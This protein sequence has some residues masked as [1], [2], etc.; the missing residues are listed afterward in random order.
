[1]HFHLIAVGKRMPAWIRTGH[2]EYAKRFP[3]ECRLHLIEIEASKRGKNFPIDRMLHEEGQRMLN[4]IP[5]N[6]F[7]VA[8]EI[9]GK[10]WDTQ[11]LSEQFRYWQQHGRDVVFLIGGPEGLSPAC[12]ARAEQRWSLSLLTL[13]HP[14]VRVIVAEQ[15][16]RAYSLL[17]GHPYHR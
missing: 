1:M 12:L 16:Y 15:L 17:Q 10:Q 14:L 5:K 13:P 8:L 11:K 3:P 9:H 7:V 4:A 2:E 6:S